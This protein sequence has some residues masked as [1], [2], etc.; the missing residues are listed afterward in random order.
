MKTRVVFE[1]W[2]EAQFHYQVEVLEDNTFNR[3]VRWEFVM[4]YS[5][6][7]EA[8]RIAKERLKGSKVV[9]EF[10]SNGWPTT[11]RMADK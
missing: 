1:P 8:V 4:A 11:G 6:E 9:A 10:D 5:T 3:D 2:Q 7:E